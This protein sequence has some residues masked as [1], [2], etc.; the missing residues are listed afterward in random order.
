MSEQNVRVSARKFEDVFSE[1]WKGRFETFSLANLVFY[2]NSISKFIDNG[3]VENFILADEIIVLHELIRDE[4][5]H[6]C[7]LMSDSRNISECKR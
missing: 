6:R 5:V 7:E 2:A 4:C 1:Y 3:F